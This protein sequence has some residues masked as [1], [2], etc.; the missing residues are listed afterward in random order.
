VRNVLRGLM[1][2]WPGGGFP[3]GDVRDTAA[4]HAAL[5]GAGRTSRASRGAGRSG[6]GAERSGLGA[7]RSGLGAGRNGRS[8][9]RSGLGAGRYF[10]PGRYVSTR[11]Y[12]QLLREITQR[13]LPAVFLPAGSMLPAGMLTTALQKVWP[14]HIPAEFGAAYTC[15]HAR[16]VADSADTLGLVPRPVHETMGDTVRWLYATGRLSARQAGAAAAVDSAG[17]PVIAR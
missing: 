11:E 6:F 10:G 16:P 12:V 5:L 3:I 13:R 9:G 4:L 2:I 7:A 1:P 8:A 14:W 17:S 15:A